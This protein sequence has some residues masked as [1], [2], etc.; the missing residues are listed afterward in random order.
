M[1]GLGT[2]GYDSCFLGVDNDSY[3]SY[4]LLEW[5]TFDDKKDIVSLLGKIMREAAVLAPT[6]NRYKGAGSDLEEEGQ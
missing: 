2:D 1:F 5:W 3:Y 4:R 6:G